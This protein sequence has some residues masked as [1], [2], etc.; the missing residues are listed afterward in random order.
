MTLT[1]EAT[2]RV[3]TTPQVEQEAPVTQGE[4]MVQDLNTLF[5]ASAHQTR[6]SY[7]DRVT[8]R[9]S[10]NNFMTGRITSD[11]LND[12]V[13]RNN[14][15]L[16]DRMQAANR[17]NTRRLAVAALGT[18]AGMAAS[19]AAAPL[20]A[21]VIGGAAGAY[22]ISR[23]LGARN[24]KA[25]IARE[26]EAIR[27]AEGT[28]RYEDADRTAQDLEDMHAN[29]DSFISRYTIARDTAA[30]E[31]R[32]AGEPRLTRFVRAFS[33]YRTKLETDDDVKDDIQARIAT[34]ALI[35][36][37]DP[38]NLD[39]AIEEQNRL[40]NLAN[41]HA[42]LA[43]TF[44]DQHNTSIRSELAYYNKITKETT[45]QAQNF[46]KDTYTL[47]DSRLDNAER[48]LDNLGY[49]PHPDVYNAMPA[50]SR[51]EYN[52]VVLATINTV[53]GSQELENLNVEINGVD[54][55]ETVSDALIAFNEN[56]IDEISLQQ[57]LKALEKGLEDNAAL[58]N[59]DMRFAAI[60]ENNAANTDS[61][62]GRTAQLAYQ[63]GISISDY[64]D[65]RPSFGERLQNAGQAGAS[66]LRR[67]GQTIGNFVRGG[68][69][70]N[71]ANLGPRGH[72]VA[73]ARPAAPT[74]TR[75]PRPA[76]PA[77]GGRRAAARP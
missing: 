70:I 27:R 15:E 45:Q 37:P 61:V 72:N 28:R 59:Q 46:I 74:Y 39:L 56:L 75:T 31:S 54:G 73:P 7:M 13:L 68:R 40:I 22:G 47:D 53:F 34:T 11:R 8:L 16:Q 32:L 51:A 33:T 57:V 3:D 20:I 69:N 58:L 35:P 76:A 17:G 1:T 52:R 9:G 21:T 41:S 2:Y 60:V 4:Q 6:N 64:Y 49:L 10:E 19:F 23:L 38:D 18:A 26:T 29:Y 55:V 12:P 50:E 66:R 43:N 77:A 71:P 25:D 14:P 63:N 24:E 36:Q 65:P 48:T 44:I 30:L 62:A 42:A 67:F 5:E